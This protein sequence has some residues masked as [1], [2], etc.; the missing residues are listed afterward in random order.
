MNKYKFKDKMP[1]EVLEAVQLSKE[2]VTEVAKWCRGIEVV[3]HDA[4]NPE[5]TYVGI[6]L[7]TFGGPSRAG[8][9]DYVVLDRSGHFHVLLSHIFESTIEPINE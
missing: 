3:E 8:E 6:N 9:S 5:N 7:M 4:L 2:N 1:N